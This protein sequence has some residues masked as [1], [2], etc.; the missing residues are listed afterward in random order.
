MYVNQYD[1]SGKIAVVTGGASGVG[2]M[3]VKMFL[4]SGVEGVIIADLNE[5]LGQK[6]TAGL[7]P[8]CKYVKADITS[9]DSMSNVVKVTEETFGCPSILV[10]CAAICFPTPLD[11]D[12]GKFYKMIEV[13]VNGTFNVVKAVAPSMKKSDKPGSIVL[14]SSVAGLLGSALNAGY[15]A[16]KFAVRGMTYT[17]AC[18]LGPKI[19]VNDVCP[20]PTETPINEFARDIIKEMAGMWPIPR[21]GIPEEQAGMICWLCSDAASFVTGQDFIVDGGATCKFYP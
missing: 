5:E 11:E 21:M 1:L 19:R 6:F 8:K 14:L 16:A 7:G 17:F 12:E 4:E 13:N 2:A 3:T 20:G 15:H 10:H 9:M 18:E